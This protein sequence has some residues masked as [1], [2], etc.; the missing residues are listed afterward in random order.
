MTS[1]ATTTHESHRSEYSHTMSTSS[2]YA[3]FALVA[4]LSL[5]V[6]DAHDFVGPNTLELTSENYEELVRAPSM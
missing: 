2:S 1:G 3:V 4:L 6:A 5:L